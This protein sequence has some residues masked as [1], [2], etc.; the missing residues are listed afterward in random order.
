MS[1]SCNLIWCEACCKSRHMSILL[2]AAHQMSHPLLARDAV[3]WPSASSK[4]GDQLPVVVYHTSCSQHYGHTTMWLR[5]LSSLSSRSSCTPFCNLSLLCLSQYNL[6]A[7]GVCS[8]GWRGV[9]C[10]KLSCLRSNPAGSA[11]ILSL[12]SCTNFSISAVRDFVCTC[13]WSVGVSD[14]RHPLRGT[15][16]HGILCSQA[17]KYEASCYPGWLMLPEPADTHAS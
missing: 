6:M 5:W 16:L 14:V 1:A 3:S 10:A 2:F 12:I 8:P 13:G 9:A 15:R 4:H 11:R 17:D 7:G